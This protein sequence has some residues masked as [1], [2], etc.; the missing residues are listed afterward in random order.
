MVRIGS[1]GTWNAG[2]GMQLLLVLQNVNSHTVETCAF[3]F[4]LQYSMVT[5][6]IMMAMAVACPFLCIYSLLGCQTHSFC[7]LAF[8][9]QNGG[10]L[11]RAI[12][13]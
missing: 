8:V 7:C 2:E 1:K 3:K 13:W 5:F 4:I 10:D 9:F 6:Y 12:G 11:T